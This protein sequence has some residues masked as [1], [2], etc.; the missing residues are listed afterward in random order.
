[1]NYIRQTLFALLLLCAAT[2]RAQF[3]QVDWGG[4]RGDSLLPVC[5]QVIDLPADYAAYRYTAR[6]EY[7]EFQKMGAAEVGRYGIASKYGNLPPMPAVECSVGVQAN[8]RS[9]M[10]HFCRWLCAAGV[11]TA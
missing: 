5:T 10:W 4:T 7:P 3:V 9:S 2:A 8:V 1:M 11:T 6:I